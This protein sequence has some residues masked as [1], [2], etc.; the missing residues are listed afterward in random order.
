M[1]AAAAPAAAPAVDLILVLQHVLQQNNSRSS[2]S[3]DAHVRKRLLQTSL[4]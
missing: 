1:T 2:M 3:S 4:L